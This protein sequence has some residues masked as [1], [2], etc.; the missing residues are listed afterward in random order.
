VRGRVVGVLD[1]HKSDET[2]HWTPED[3]AI[4]EQLTDQLGVALE[5]ARLYQDVQRGAVRERLTHEITDQMRRATS[6]DGI[7]Q[8]AVDALFSVMGTSRAFVQL[9][10]VNP[11]ED[12]GENG[13]QR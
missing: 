4:L 5:S 1:T 8:T 3:I 13:H 6:V 12:G 7:V 9:E 11:E 10:D 2:G